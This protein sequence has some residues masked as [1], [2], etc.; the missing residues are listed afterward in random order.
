MSIDGGLDD[1]EESVRIAVKALDDMRNSTSWVPTPSS[2]LLP[3]SF[4]SFSLISIVEIVIDI[5][6]PSAHNTADSEAP[7]SPAFVERMSHIPFVNSA[8]RVYEQGKAS[9][10]VVKVCVSLSSF[11]SLKSP[12]LF[13]SPPKK[14]YS[15]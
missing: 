8:L 3:P 1:H 15:Y 12:F 2:P 6:R 4:P 13:L 5:A 14:I 9:S 10:R 7:N 11:L